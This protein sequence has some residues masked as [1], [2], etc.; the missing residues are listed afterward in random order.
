MY[1]QIEDVR[2]G[3]N[4]SRDVSSHLTIFH[5]LLS[6]KL[7]KHDESLAWLKDEAQLLFGA[8]MQTLKTVDPDSCAQRS[9]PVLKRSYFMAIL[10][11]A[12]PLEQPTVYN[13]SSNILSPLSPLKKAKDHG[14][15]LLNTN[16]RFCLA[17]ASR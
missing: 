3:A 14:P 8:G 7:P 1:R 9:I 6:C 10:V 11:E 15:Y 12:S 16:K 2:S 13:E 17:L 4:A 5:D